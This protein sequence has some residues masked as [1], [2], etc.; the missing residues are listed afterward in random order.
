MRYTFKMVAVALVFSAMAA[1]AD[2]ASKIPLQGGQW[3]IVTSTRF[4]GM[5]VDLPPVPAKTVQCIAQEQIDSHQ[6]LKKVKGPQGEC[7]VSNVHV[8]KDRI[9]WDMK[10]VGGQVA[11]NAKGAVT[12]ITEQLFTGKV[13]FSSTPGQSQLG[14]LKGV[15]TVQGTRVGDC[16]PNFV[17]PY[18]VQQ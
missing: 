10:C 13:D 1:G 7:D 8:Q 9:T 18:A 6:F 15:V 5:P 2:A 14:Q 16:D 17:A 3:E 11:V 12:P 4:L